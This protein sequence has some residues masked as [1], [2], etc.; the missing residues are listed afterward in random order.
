MLIATE[1][2]GV[3]GVGAVVR[4]GVLAAR[5]EPGVEAVRGGAH[6][7]ARADC[8]A[9]CTEPDRWVTSWAARTAVAPMPLSRSGP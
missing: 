7:T 2:T 6:R 9:M 1:A 4:S 3:G 5:E 8:S